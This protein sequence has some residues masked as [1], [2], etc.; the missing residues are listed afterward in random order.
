MDYVPSIIFTLCSVAASYSYFL[1]LQSTGY[2][3]Q[4]GYVNIVKTI[5]FWLYLAGGIVLELLCARWYYYV[6]FLILTSVPQWI[7]KRKVRVAFTKRMIRTVTVTVITQFVLVLVIGMGYC[8]ALLFA[9]VLLSWIALL[10][11]ECIISN[12]YISKARQKISSAKIPIIGITG[13]YGKTSTKQ[14]LSCFL[15]DSIAPK[16]SCNTPLGIA[17][18]INK[19]DLSRAKYIILE[20][21][22]RQKWDIKRLCRL[23]PP[24]YG[25]LTGIGNQH[26]S[27]FGSFN[28][29]VFCKQQLPLCINMHGLCVL[30]SAT[31]AIKYGK[32]GRCKKINSYSN[33]QIKCVEVDVKGSVFEVTYLQKNA[34]IRLPLIASHTKDTLAM[35]LQLCFALGQTF[36]QTIDNAKKVC[37]VEH[38]M[39][40]VPCG[41]FYIIDDSYNACIEGVQSCVNTLKHFNCTKVVITQGIVECGKQK[42]QQNIKCGQLLAGA[43]NV[44]ITLGKNSKLLEQG[45]CQAGCSSILHAKSLTQ[46]VQI[47][48]QYVGNGLLIF[49]NDLPDS[50]NVI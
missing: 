27:T 24:Q 34:L 26:L 17:K 22:A 23:F 50:V 20:Y 25:I 30:N 14:M 5:W 18:F 35:V 7:K 9:T 21:G 36:E 47:A 19:A 3:P 37:G 2:K 33:I 16:G 48:R 1:L 32:V 39:Q 4:R 43:V 6:L 29:I 31:N 46:A 15:D 41:T 38:R 13:S 42:R 11:V 44:A 49:Q 40:L 45:L 12:Y 28:D 8:M 10:P